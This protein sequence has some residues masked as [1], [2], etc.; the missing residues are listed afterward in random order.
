ML[1]INVVRA[2]VMKPIITL[3]PSSNVVSKI[4]GNLSSAL[5]CWLATWKDSEFIDFF[6]FLKEKNHPRQKKS[7]GSVLLEP[8]GIFL[9]GIFDFDLCEKP[10]YN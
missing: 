8:F 6:D 4:A 10:Q 1:I 2:D 5:T 3:S 7:F 9:G